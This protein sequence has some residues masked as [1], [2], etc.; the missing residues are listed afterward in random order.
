MKDLLRSVAL[1]G[2]FV[3]PFLPL[4]VTN[5]LFFPFITG[6]NFIFRVVVEVVFV[7]WAMLALYEPKYRPRFSYIL[8]AV[9]S[10][11]GI[12]L[13]A[14]LSG[15]NT[16]KSLWSN[17]ERMEGFVA[18][19]HVGLYVLAAA[20]ILNTQ[21][22]W[23]YFLNTTIAAASLVSIYAFAQ[24]GG[25]IQINQGGV[26]VDATLGNAAYFAIY[27]LFHVFIAGYLSVRATSKNMQR[28]YIGFALI[29]AYLLY[30]TATR[31]TFGGLVVG[32][33]VAASY[34]ALFSAGAVRIRNYAAGLLLLVV[35]LVGTLY[36]ART[37]SF[38]QNNE[39]LARIASA[40]SLRSLDTRLVIWNMAW[41]GVKER[42]VLGWG[43]ENFNYVFNQNYDPR[44]HGEEPWFDRVHNIFFDWLIA[45]GVLGFVAYFAIYFSAIYYVAIRPR[46]RSWKGI[47]DVGE[48]SVTEQGVLLGLLA[49][50]MFHNLFVFDNII[51]YLFYGTILALIHTRV[52]VAMP[53]F[54][55][56]AVSKVVID[57]IFMPVAG[58]VL[59]FG[60]YVLNVPALLAASDII[61]GFQEQ[62]VDLRL[63]AFDRALSR[64]SFGN[65][66]IREQLTR[67]TQEALQQQ[68]L[69]D[70]DK[71]K[72]KKKTE[73]ELVNQ[74]SDTPDD[75]RIRVFISSFYRLTG[76]PKHALEELN[77][78]LALS[79]NKQQ[80]LFEK[81]LAHLQLND[82]PSAVATFKKAYDLA[83][84][85]SNARMFY[86][87]AALYDKNDALFNELNIPDYKDTYY[88]N[89]FVLRAA[90]DT[91][92]FDLIKDILGVRVTKN[93]NDLQTRVSLAVAHNESGDTATA[94]EILE[95][96]TKDF[97]DFKEQGDGYIAQLKSGKKPAN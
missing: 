46:I 88:Q 57:N 58:V 29:F 9:L 53:S 96:A 94:I 52:S 35:V 34:I 19:F 62:T 82:I 50:Y 67:V 4:V 10:W 93:P 8:V 43:Q 73:E 16:Q 72:F 14:D 81:G 7:A 83:P 49:G 40:F 65:Q 69:P 36:V 55:K 47:A 84:N 76:D 31:G 22:L 97:P 61:G 60:I 89:D 15:I 70:A 17:F 51:S 12:I 24:L 23:N 59:L 30:Q 56:T 54:E 33:G 13:A 2:I 75:A 44:L 92:R 32:L 64:N 3:L 18:I 77:A 90:Y 1:A 85:Y 37:S 20:H 78:A 91:K 79:P 80:I 38:V 42:P 11:L 68:G 45:G 27:M 48:F 66:E 39:A 28:L 86:M 26:R 87:A 95:Q 74:I 63:A 5:S 71:A 41:E 6:K 21:K 25:A